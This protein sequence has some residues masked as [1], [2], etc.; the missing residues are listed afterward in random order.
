MRSET[1][2]CFYIFVKD[3]DKSLEKVWIKFG[4]KF[5]EKF[6]KFGVKKKGQNLGPL[7]GV[8]LYI[9]F[10]VNFGKVQFF[11][12]KKIRKILGKKVRDLKKGKVKLG[13]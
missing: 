5:G 11:G 9:Y 10:S 6:G 4:E 12:G 7:G 2:S 13:Q 1:V 3:F 8:Y